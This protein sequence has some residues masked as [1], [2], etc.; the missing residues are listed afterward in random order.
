MAPPADERRGVA[1]A[2]PTRSTPASLKSGVRS[3]LSVATS[4]CCFFHPSQGGA[5]FPGPHQGVLATLK[6]DPK[7]VAHHICLYPALSGSDVCASQFPV[8]PG[9]ALS[10]EPSLAGWSVARPKRH[11][12]IGWV[13]NQPPRTC[14]LGFNQAQ[15]G[16]NRKQKVPKSKWVTKTSNRFLCLD[17]AS[18]GLSSLQTGAEWE[19]SHSP[20]EL[21]KVIEI[22]RH[23]DFDSESLVSLD[24][25]I[26]DEPSNSAVEIAST[27]CDMA[28]F[29]DGDARIQNVNEALGDSSKNRQNPLSIGL[30]N[31][32]SIDQHKFDY[33]VNFLKQ[34]KNSMLCLTELSSENRNTINVLAKHSDFPTLTHPDNKR[35]G[36]MLPNYLKDAVEIV[37]AWS[38]CQKRNRNSDKAV[39]LTIFKV[40]LSSIV[41]TII[42]VYAAPDTNIE[43]KR[44]L[45]RK[46]CDL[47]KSFPNAITV[48]DFNIDLKVKEKKRFL[49]TELGGLYSQVVN[50]FT[51]VKTRNIDGSSRTSKTCIDLVFL[52]KDI[53][54]KLI[55]K[56]VIIKDAP[57]DHYLVNFSLDI[58]VASKYVVKEYF[59]DPT[60]RRPIPKSKL[61]E[62]NDALS[63]L[64]NSRAAD[65]DSADRAESFKLLNELM[66]QILDVFAPMNEPKLLTKKIYRFVMPPELRKLKKPLNAAKNKWRMAVRQKKKA[67]IVANCREKFRRLRNNY[68]RA[69]KNC[70][71]KQKASK[72]YDGI[73]NNNNIWS[74]IKKFLPDPDYRPPS[75]KMEIKGKSGK[76]LADHMAKFFY[77]RAHLV[78]DEEADEFK[79]F[80]PMPSVDPSIKIDFD[81][82]L[83]YT[84]E[85][86]FQGKKKPSLAAG[87][88][89]ISHRHIVDLMPSLKECLQDSVEK[90][91]TEFTDISKSYTRLLNKDAV[92]SKSILV[93]KSQRPIAELNCLPKYG[94]IKIFVDQLRKELLKV[95]KKNQ[96]AFPGKGGPMAIVQT[97]D[98]ASE[99]SSKGNKTLILFWDFSNAFCTTIHKI[100]VAVA[101]KFN[102]SDR[103]M[104]LLEQFLSQSFSAI[105]FSDKNG[106][107]ISDEIDM[108][109]GTPQGQIGSDLIFALVNDNIDPIQVLDE[110]IIRT[111]YVDDFTDVLAATSISTLFRSY[112]CNEKHLKN[113]ATSVGLKLNEG[114]TKIVPMN[115]HPDDL[116][117]EFRDRY[118]YQEELLGFK[119]SVKGA[120]SHLEK[121]TRTS[122]SEFHMSL[123]HSRKPGHFTTING[124]PAAN[125]LI[126]RLASA[127][128]T[129]YT[130]RKFEKNSFINLQAA[131]SLVWSCC[132][133]LGC[134]RAYC[135][136][137]S[138]N[139]VCKSIR[140]VIKAAGLDHMTNSEVVYRISTGYSPD[141]MALK[142]IVQLGIKFLD[143]DSFSDSYKV[144]SL[145]SDVARPF[146]HRFV[147]EFNS[148]PYTLREFIAKTLD[149]SSKSEMNKI[150]RRLKSHYTVLY[151]PNGKLSKE[152][153]LKLLDENS[154]SK[155]KIEKRKRDYEDIRKSRIE[156]SIARAKR[157]ESKLFITPKKRRKKFSTSFVTPKVLREIAFCFGP[158][159][160]TTNKD[161]RR[162]H[163]IDGSTPIKRQRENLAI[164]QAGLLSKRLRLDSISSVSDDLEISRREMVDMVQMDFLEKPLGLFESGCLKEGFQTSITLD[165][166]ELDQSINSE[167]IDEIERLPI[168]NFSPY[169]WDAEC[170]DE[171]K[172]TVI[173][174]VVPPCDSPVFERQLPD[175]DQ[176]AS[177]DQGQYKIGPRH[178][179]RD[180]LKQLYR[181]N[182]LRPPEKS[183]SS[184]TQN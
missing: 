78:S 117:V 39:Q 72:L 129:M 168:F 154:Y 86:L 109:R 116:P 107:Y 77:D 120:P 149:P 59:L 75:F 97:L 50:D 105:K 103:M 169:V 157:E 183:K 79:T 141:I 102:L 85:E 133:D 61:K 25:P 8:S 51:R 65:F 63:K 152:K 123:R 144:I 31:I 49:M 108:V 181:L 66:V 73:M 27:Q 138:W 134:I 162:D 81:D 36:I 104:A 99:Q 47:G 160:D 71:N 167:I 35:V 124:D 90:P 142:Q 115:I 125:E 32:N 150:K 17:D 68:N 91:L 15:F 132:Y 43:G 143:E 110:I 140:K 74:I 95:L 113:S 4:R 1:L 128:R 48:G 22:G 153:V 67:S 46:L 28:E 54:Q 170:V 106:Y 44:A 111:K 52:T 89:T 58:K 182:R 69:V 164:N 64:I 172:T 70:R 92:T 84:V 178:E 147:T 94:S 2:T 174:N 37:D 127:T 101:K 82:N 33:C 11:R 18:Q 12:G 112:K 30:W 156:A 7:G 14:D 83:K 159:K 158:S 55:D 176:I 29:S 76:E 42:V 20:R 80:I 180:R 23:G 166:I 19:I 155:E 119:F 161:V 130:L 96:Y 177:F 45:C 171:T 179:K 139:D 40:N 34:E 62:A 53:K 57:S 165:E 56:P 137:S 122:Q 121:D 145:E 100:I 38:W 87:P 21:N 16:F 3:A 88:D 163:V 184:G 10:T 41:M 146:W 6:A 5:T 135:S 13:A 148:L 173:S 136:D 9:T 175:V 151:N 93:E 114:K 60:R 118:V 26:L 24:R 98:D 126:S 131:T